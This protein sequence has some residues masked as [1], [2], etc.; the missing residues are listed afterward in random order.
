MA[1]KARTH[2][3]RRN[4]DGR[5]PLERDRAGN[6]WQWAA[7]IVG[8]AGLVSAAAGLTLLLF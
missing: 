8:G 6:R 1:L 3:S 5:L 4:H 2:F 7:R